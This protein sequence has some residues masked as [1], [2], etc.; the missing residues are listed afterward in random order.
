MKTKILLLLLIGLA[1]ALHATTK[2]PLIRDE[3]VILDLLNNGHINLSDDVAKAMTQKESERRVRRI[4]LEKDG[5]R[6]RAAFRD[7]S[8]RIDGRR[9]R[10]PKYYDAYYNEL[11]AYLVAKYLGLNIIPATVLRSIPISASGLRPSSRLRQGTL[12]LW[13]ENSIV[14]FDLSAK[15]INYPG[16]AVFRNQQLRE[17]LAM[18]CIIGNVDRHAGNLLIDL[19][20]RFEV[21][22]SR[23]DKMRPYLGKIWAID[24]SRAFHANARLEHRYCNLSK[25]KVRAISIPFIQ[26]MRS[27]KV[28]EIDAILRSSGLSHQQIDNLHLGSMDR[29]VQ[30]LKGHFEAAQQ[31]SGLADEQ[32]YSSGVWHRVR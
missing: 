4:G 10:E 32:F 23:K 27:W 12:Q 28:E 2:H 22:P 26:H 3:N 30:L 6:I 16:N 25:L 13:V 18:D 24:H 31:K 11:A 15:G 9:T 8:V 14:E 7:K 29:R 1:Y 5:W 21:E 20:E 17:I 19:N